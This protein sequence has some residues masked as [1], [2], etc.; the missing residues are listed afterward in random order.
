MSERCNMET[1]SQGP[2]RQMWL[3]LRAGCARGREAAGQWDETEER[4]W[5][6]FFTSWFA[7]GQEMYFCRLDL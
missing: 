3:W 2:A 4:G 1:N 5:S 7:N 6:Q